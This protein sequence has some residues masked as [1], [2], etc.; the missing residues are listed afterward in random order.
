MRLMDI[1]LYKAWVLKNGVVA[2]QFISMQ[3]WQDI[4]AGHTRLMDGSLKCKV[5]C[6]KSEF[7]V[8]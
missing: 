5:H 3:L 6:K 8:D 1:V 7:P 4:R 2:M